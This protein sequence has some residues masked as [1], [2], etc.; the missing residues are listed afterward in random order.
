MT[1]MPDLFSVVIVTWNSAS[2]IEACLEAVFRQAKV[3]TEVIVVD[4]GSTDDTP[5]LLQKWENRIKPIFCGENLGFCR[6]CNLGLDRA[7]GGYVIFL[8]ADTIMEPDY[9][10]AISRAFRQNG[11][12]GLIGGKLFRFDGKTLD[13]CGQILSRGRKVIDRGYGRPDRG[14]YEKTEKVFSVCGAA[15]SCK[16]AL[17]QELQ[18]EGAFFDEDFHSFYEDLDIGWRASRCGWEALYV[19]TAI[20][21]HFRGGTENRKSGWL[22]RLG[23]TARRD[24]NIKIHIMKNR[25]LVMLKNDTPREV[26]KNFPF[27]LGREVKLWSFY[28][29]TSPSLALEFWRSRR[30]WKKALQKRRALTARRKGTD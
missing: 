11:K 27:I 28:L 6:A 2:F 10:A 15:L 7:N 19:P 16:R 21:R 8:N 3:R 12:A 9:L 13:S 20:A 17:I 29:L 4:N 26:L 22:S 14:H 30:L 24:K 18:A 25:Y 1:G 5:E 23:Q